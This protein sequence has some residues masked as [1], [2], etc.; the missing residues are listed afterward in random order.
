MKAGRIFAGTTLAIALAIPAADALACG[1]GAGMGATTM[2]PGVA[3]A[4][5]APVASVGV[6]V[7]PVGLTVSA[8]PAGYVSV[9]VGGVGFFR[10]GPAWYQPFHGPAGMM[11]RV[12]APPHG[13][14]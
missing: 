11:F 5:P 9:V 8:L 14:M 1:P 13:A 4:L 6:A 3:V 12:V 7:P 2:A 10:A